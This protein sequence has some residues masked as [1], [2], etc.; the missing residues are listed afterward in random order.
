M[1]NGNPNFDLAIADAWFSSLASTITRFS[2]RHN[3]YVDKYYHESSCWSLRF[4]HPAGGVGTI[5]I[6]Q[7]GA[8]QVGI[9]AHWHLDDEAGGKRSLL[10]RPRRDLNKDSALLE[11]ALREELLSLVTT[12]LGQWTQV[13]DL[14]PPDDLPEGAVV[15]RPQ[16]PLPRL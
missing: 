6:L 5:D 2:Q 15:I 7:L 16:Y 11:E 12:P 13:S 1:P 10:W 3:L 8:E 14:S 9:G 4:A